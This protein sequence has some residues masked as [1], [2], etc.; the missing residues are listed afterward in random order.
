MISLLG[1][2]AEWS[3]NDEHHAG[4]AEDRA[5]PADLDVRD[6]QKVA[7]T[8]YVRDVQPDVGDGFP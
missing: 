1:A 5:T 2:P 8:F 7:G 4:H 3:Q 6:R